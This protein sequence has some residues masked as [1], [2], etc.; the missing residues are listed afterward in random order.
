MERLR[1]A[2]AARRTVRGRA[3]RIRGSYPILM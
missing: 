2:H 3:V 1:S